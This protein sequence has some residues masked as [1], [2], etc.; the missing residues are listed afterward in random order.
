LKS[1]F[2]ILICL[3]TLTSCDKFKTKE[4]IYRAALTGEVPSLDPAI[5]YD[6]V[7]ARIVY[8][9]YEQLYEYHYLKRP[10]QIQ[11][12][13]AEGMPVISN[14]GRDYQIKIKKDVLY[15]DNPAFNGQKRSVRCEDFI[16]QFKRLAYKPT[17]SNGWWL[18]QTKIK[19]LDEFREQTFP[20]LEEMLSSKIEGLSCIDDYHLH[21]KLN[22]PSSEFV[23]YLTMSFVSPL[24][25]E[26]IVA[27]NNDLNEKMVGTGPFVLTEWDKSY[28]LVLKRNKEYRKAYYPKIGDRVANR[29]NLLEDA[30]VQIPFLDQIEFYIL[31]ETPERWEYFKQGKIDI[32]TLNQNNIDE[33]VDKSGVLKDA[34]AKK[35]IDLQVSPTLTFWWLSFNLNDPILGKNRNLR[36]AIIHAI[37]IEHYIKV[38]TQNTGQKA[39]SI[40]IPG[41]VGYDPAKVW[42]YQHDLGK[43]KRYLEQAGYPD[44]K[45]LPTLIFD[46]RGNTQ[47]HEL[48]GE[49]VKKALAQIGIKVMIMKNSFPDFLEK[50]R[51]GKLQFWYDG[52]TLDYP[53]ADNILQ[54]LTTKNFPPGPNSTYFS[55]PKFDELYQKLKSTY[56]AKERE[57]ILDQMESIVI[58]NP[59]WVLLYYARDYI[60][61]HKRVK[62]YRH[63]DI[64]FNDAKY[65]RVKPD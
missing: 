8:Q 9:S 31:K 44:G 21:V 35:K 65:L 16:N 20:G 11:P 64:I 63:S 6:T 40:F 14:G 51:S 61:S 47:T 48:R 53:D 49:F 12:L 5:S 3:L 60:L 32:L 28:R 30:G 25:K 23:Y 52:W 39:N 26:A 4:Q 33:A 59:P 62:N 13:L 38:F 42:P 50:S 22:Q 7:S 58:D 45:N 55:D 18:F 36:K 19:G 2:L 10:Y 57:K 43:A 46:V 56:E 54:L 24:P 37:N 29:L 34:M 41:L 17:N 27:Y 15:H 1:F